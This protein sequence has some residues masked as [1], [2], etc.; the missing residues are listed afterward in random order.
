MRRLAGMFFDA[1]KRTIAA[2]LAIL[3]VLIG[4]AYVVG[5]DYQ[6]DV[7]LDDTESVRAFT[8][9]TDHDPDLKTDQL[10][11]AWRAQEGALSPQ[12]RPRIEAFLDEVAAVEDVSSIRTPWIDAQTARTQVSQDGRTALANVAFE[13]ADVPDA[14]IREILRLV[15]EMAASP[16]LTVGVTGSPIDQAAPP[17][18]SASEIVGFVIAGVILLLAF[19]SLVAAV[20]PLAT[21]LIA[22]GAGLAVVMM[23][24]HVLSIP[25]FAP[26]MVSL[27]SIGVG[28]DYALF[29]VSRHRSDLKGG[30]SVREATIHA[31][32]SSG[33]A[34]IFA[35]ITVVIALLGMLATGI[36]FLTGL[37][38]ATSIGVLFTMLV[39]ISLLPALLALIGERVLS[40][41]ERARLRESGPSDEAASNRWASWARVIQQRPWP[42]IAAAVAILLV[43]SIPAASLRLGMSDAGTDA[44]GTAQRVGYDLISDG[45]GP[46][47]NGPLLLV[48]TDVEALSAA[49][50]GLEGRDGV[51]FVS[52]PQTTPDG[53]IGTVTVVPTTGPQ[54]EGTEALI[55]ALRSDLAG[56]SIAVSG[57]AAVY[58]D[59]SRTLQDRLPWFLVGVLGLSSVLLLIA[60]RSIAIPVKAA[61]MNLLAAGAS[62]GVLVVV[63]Q[64]GW[65]GTLLGIDR[66]GPV[67]AFLPIL[68]LAVLFGLSMDYQV[69]LVSRMR[70]EWIN[71]RDNTRAVTIGLAQTG[72]VITAAALIMIAVF[73]SFV[74]GSDR[75]IKLIGLGLAVAIFLD[76]FVIRSLLVPALMRVLGDW[77]WWLP[78]WL[79]RLV[80]RVA[81][82]PLTTPAPVIGSSY[83]SHQR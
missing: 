22:L 7:N 46:G 11:I 79:D 39:T 2:W 32:D 33:R 43:L 50:A 58:Y 14:S 10:T 56:S 82:E 51:A 18:A 57:I 77:N 35:G 54:A 38:V 16:D 63:S 15:D 21:A 40:R 47:F 69:F 29:V 30:M 19:G 59:F 17:T 13:D 55:D 27:I 64:W 73:T 20:L 78:R 34:V 67:D 71:T 4:A 66:T 25:S 26:Q 9:L 36:G 49:A 1:P 65:L 68:L 83:G 8:D 23:T 80:P 70:E 28:I 41:R 42:F 74:F 24:T 75:I 5:T 3:T 53:A 48:S 72:R 6:F 31:L 60:F 12:V 61:V 52:P 81:I 76:A 44:P 37:A 45:F 62:F